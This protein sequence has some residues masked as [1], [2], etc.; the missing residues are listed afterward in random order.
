MTVSAGDGTCSASQSFTWNVNGPV[1]IVTPADQT[2]NEGDTVSLS[3]SASDGRSGTLTYGAAG[4][5]AGLSINASTGAI[6]GTI[7]AGA[8][9]NGPYTVTLLAEDGTY[10]NE[11][12]STG[13]STVR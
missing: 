11:P 2:N 1:N 4:L 9:A 13:T 3:I 10:C 6:S 7:S 5:P 12:P 8:A